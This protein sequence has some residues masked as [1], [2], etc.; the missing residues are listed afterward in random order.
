M[1]LREAKRGFE[2]LPS[3]GLKKV[4]TVAPTAWSVC[5]SVVGG[6]RL[7]VGGCS[8]PCSTSNHSHAPLCK[9]LDL[10]LLV[11]GYIQFS[12]ESLLSRDS[13]FL[14]LYIFDSLM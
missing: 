13:P 14:W 3:F 1:P 9:I 5:H 7:G 10:F 11:T 12:S 8:H 4:P 6:K 2:C